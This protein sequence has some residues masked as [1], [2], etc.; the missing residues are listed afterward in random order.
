[1][2]LV[3]D[4]RLPARDRLRRVRQDRE[5]AFVLAAFGIGRGGDGMVSAAGGPLRFRGGGS[6]ESYLETDALRVQASRAG[7]WWMSRARCSASP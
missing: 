4:M 1:V 7:L 6:V 2:L 5:V 3:S